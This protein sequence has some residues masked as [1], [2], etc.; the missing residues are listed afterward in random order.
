MSLRN[1]LWQ[2]SR[3]GN[4]HGSV[5]SHSTAAPPNSSFKA[6]WRVGDAVV[7]KG[8]AGWTTSKSGHPCPCQNCSP[9]PSAKTTERGSL[10]NRPHLSLPDDPIGQGTELHRP[11]LEFKERVKPES[12]IFAKKN[13]LPPICADTLRSQLQNS[14]CIDP[15]LPVT[16]A[17]CR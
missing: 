7:G 6:S 4:L 5:T 11:R 10:L 12:C 8:N 2:L 1:L 13:L 17:K 16:I 14:I 9:W 3:D 15:M